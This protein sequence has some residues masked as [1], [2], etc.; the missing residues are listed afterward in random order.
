M[1]TSM[2]ATW[3]VF[4]SCGKI[5]TSALCNI[6][7]NLLTHMNNYL[8]SNSAFSLLEIEAW[9]LS[10]PSKTMVWTSLT[11]LLFIFGLFSMYIWVCHRGRSKESRRQYEN[12]K[13]ISCNFLFLSYMGCSYALYPQY[14]YTNLYKPMQY[15]FDLTQ[16]GIKARAFNKKSECL[17]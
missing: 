4:N 8:H 7:A 11:S 1:V 15:A 17:S 5:P 6:I 3:F 10:R 9:S 13:C 14:D 12:R 16:L 2:D